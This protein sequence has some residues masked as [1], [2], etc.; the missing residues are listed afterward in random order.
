MWKARPHPIPTS[1]SRTRLGGGSQ[2]HPEHLGYR[3]VKRARVLGD[4]YPAANL[5]RRAILTEAPK[6]PGRPP[7]QTDWFRHPKRRLPMKRCP[8]LD[9]EP[10]LGRSER[11][12]APQFALRAVRSFVLSAAPRFAAH[13]APHCAPSAEQQAVPLDTPRKPPPWLRRRCA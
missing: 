10:H 3:P 11:P 1:R 9:R 2:H 12:A 5:G 13:A 8:L 4:V 6:F 7:P